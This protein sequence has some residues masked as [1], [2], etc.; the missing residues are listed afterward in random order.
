MT[1]RTP[2]PY[3]V[4]YARQD[5]KLVDD[6]LGRLA[7]YVEGSRRYVFNKWKDT[8]VLIGESWANEIPRALEC[9]RIG[10]LMVSPTFLVRPYIGVMEVPVFVQ[11][12]KIV[13]PILIKP[14]DTQL[15]NLGE[16]DGLRLFA[17]RG[18]GQPRAYSEFRGERRDAFALELYRAIEARLIKDM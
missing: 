1:V 11:P 14:V 5:S 6:L 7:P 13:L 15:Q 18:K 4:S 8:D 10:L 3:F 16:L 2:A 12:G 17:M 9:H